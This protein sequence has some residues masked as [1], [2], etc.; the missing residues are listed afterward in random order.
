MTTL[1]QLHDIN[2]GR[3]VVINFDHVEM[4]FER[5][6]DMGTTIVG[7]GQVESMAVVKESLEQIAQ[8]VFISRIL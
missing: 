1:V 2:D 5:G 3:P 4:Y 7:P 8:L 6:E